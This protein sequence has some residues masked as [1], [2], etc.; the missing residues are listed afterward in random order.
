MR[1]HEKA[2][3]V[4]LIPLAGL[5]ARGIGYHPVHIRRLE[6]SG[7]FPQRVHL[8]PGKVGWVATEVDAWLA[9]RIAERDER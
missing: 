3:A 5:R 2:S 1:E 6:K 8:G 9:E 7:R 4:T